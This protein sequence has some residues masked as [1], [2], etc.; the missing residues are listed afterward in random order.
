MRLRKIEETFRVKV[1]IKTGS[2]KKTKTKKLSKSIS[3]SNV[4][5]LCV[6]RRTKDPRLKMIIWSSIDDFVN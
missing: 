1:S 4:L 2:N 6:W 5:R 3:N